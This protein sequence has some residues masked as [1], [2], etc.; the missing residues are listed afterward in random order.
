MTRVEYICVPPKE[1]EAPRILG[2]NGYEY[3]LD[4]ISR[5]WRIWIRTTTWEEIRRD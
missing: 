3:S 5:D 1:G 2:E 4:L